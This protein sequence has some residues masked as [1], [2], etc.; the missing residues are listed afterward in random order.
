M[1]GADPAFSA[2]TGDSPLMET[3]APAQV[4]FVKGHGTELIDD[5]GRSYLDFLSGIAVTSLGHCHPRVTEALCAQAEKLWHV[6]NLFGNELAGPL[7]REID[8]LVGDGSAVGGK[9]FF[10]NSGAEAN[11]CAIKLARKAAEPGR[12]H[13]IS[14]LGSFHGRTLATLHATGQPDKHAAFQPLPAGFCHVPFGDLEALDRAADPSRVTA[15]LL[16]AIQGEGGVI[17]A[18]KGYLAAVRELCD[19]RG[20]L[21]MLDEIQTG[22]ARSGRWFAFQEAGILPDVVTIAKALGNGMPIGACWARPEVAAAFRPGDHGS[23]F[24][25]QPLACSAAL[26]TLAE[27]RRIDAPR[28][29][30]EAGERLRTGLEQLRSVESVRGRGLLLGAVLSSSGPRAKD[31]VVSALEHGLVLNA[32]T[33]GVLRLA[34][35]LTVSHTEIDKAIEILDGVLS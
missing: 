29:A 24:G 35:P 12:R 9:V 30:R 1:T 11:E 4:C 25:G 28:L 10:S 19:E 31:V 2:G 8:E 13:I 26:A 15:V 34:P 23:T 22:L 3:Y 17:P 18:P 33:A 27:L 14:A 32:P 16:E 20:I 7:A 5:T 21:L 6:S